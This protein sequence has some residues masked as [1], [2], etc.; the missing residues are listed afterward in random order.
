VAKLAKSH[1]TFPT[2]EEKKT[3]ILVDRKTRRSRIANL[4]MKKEIL[5]FPAAQKEFD[6]T[7]NNTLT[8]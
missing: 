8:S 3:K 7:E 4:S 1:K 5:S 6:H 2:T